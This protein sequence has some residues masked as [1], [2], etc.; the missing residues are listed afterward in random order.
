MHGGPESLGCAKGC[1]LLAVLGCCIRFFI[2][3]KKMAACQELKHEA[4]K[5]PHVSYSAA[6]VVSAC[7]C[8]AAQ[9]LWCGV[10]HRAIQLLAVCK[11]IATCLCC[12]MILPYKP[13]CRRLAV[14]F[15]C[16]S[17]QRFA[18]KPFGAF[19]HG[20]L[21]VY[22]AGL[23]SNMHAFPMSN[24]GNAHF[25]QPQLNHSQYSVSEEHGV[26]PVPCFLAEPKSPITRCISPSGCI[27]RFILLG[28]TSP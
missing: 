21:T 3:P 25:S 26:S 13:A 28:F 20:F 17:G 6:N 1:V 7:I 19:Y 12:L 10:W 27:A 23:A 24:Q 4:S 18:E 15:A 22:T 14:P 16:G 5:A 9:H 11:E 8:K 2:L